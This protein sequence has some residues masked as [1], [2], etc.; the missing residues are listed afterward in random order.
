LAKLEI[1]KKLTIYI[2][3]NIKYVKVSIFYYSIKKNLINEFPLILLQP[4][5][6]LFKKSLIKML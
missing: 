1:F 2:S 6:M 5:K 3:K 4:N